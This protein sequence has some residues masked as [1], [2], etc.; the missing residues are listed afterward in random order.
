MP[1]ITETFKK[2]DDA[3]HGWLLARYPRSVGT[4]EWILD[5][6]VGIFS[7]PIFAVVLAL[8]LA[9]LAIISARYIVPIAMIVAW[10]IACFGII[11]SE[12]IRELRI[13]SRTLVTLIAVSILAMGFTAFSKWALK[14]Y[15]DQHAGRIHII[16]FTPHPISVGR[17]AAIN[18]YYENT[19]DS[20]VR[21]QGMS[22]EVVV[23]GLATHPDSDL[24]IT[25]EAIYKSLKMGE[26]KSDG[27]ILTISPHGNAW[28]TILTQ[29]PIDQQ[30]VDSISSGDALIL[31]LG[32]MR[33]IDPK[34]HP[35]VEFCVLWG[36]RDGVIF[37]CPIH[38]IE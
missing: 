30:G 2:F 36:R 14:Q 9:V 3:A 15:E 31:T 24:K 1:E 12:P 8:V 4:I 10:G 37:Q 6:I 25:E 20:P 32:V 26:A 18:I 33:Y 28:N 19:G 5:F 23:R 11:R 7:A 21:F 34:N 38:N 22:Q 17:V 27:E 16:R 29:G 13:I 35:D